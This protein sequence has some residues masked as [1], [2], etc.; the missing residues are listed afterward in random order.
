MSALKFLI[1]NILKHMRSTNPRRYLIFFLIKFPFECRRNPVGVPI[2]DPS[3]DN[4]YKNI[5]FCKGKA[6]EGE[7]RE[8]REGRGREGKE[9]RE[10]GRRK[11]GGKEG[12]EGGR[13]E[14][15]LMTP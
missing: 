8:G 7:G 13:K 5:H 1:L 11:K 4:I 9:G 2:F 15:L 14:E 3:Y 12:R 6:R 10:E